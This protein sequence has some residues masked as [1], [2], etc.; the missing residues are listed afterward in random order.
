VIAKNTTTG[1][2]KISTKDG[3]WNSI[4]TRPS[5][6]ISKINLFVTLQK[7]PRKDTD[8]D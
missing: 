2:S 5:A 4:L 6:T 3:K 8:K 1:S 7:E